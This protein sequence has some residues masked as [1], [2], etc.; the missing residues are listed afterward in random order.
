MPP[1]LEEHAEDIFLEGNKVMSLESNLVFRI[2]LII[3]FFKKKVNKEIKKT[4]EAS[5]IN[6]ESLLNA[7]TTNSGVHI[8]TNG[9]HSN[10]N[11]S[12]RIP[13]LEEVFQQFPTTPVNL[14]IKFNSDDLIKKVYDLILIINWVRLTEI[15]KYII[16]NKNKVHE[17][18][19]KYNR[20]KITIWGSFRENT[21]KKCYKLNSKV[22]LYFSLMGVVKLLLLSISGLL[23]FVPLKETHL[24]IIMPNNLLK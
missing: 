3:S 18:I 23:P 9:E 19:V 2:N 24:N 7:N 20:E 17:L 12:K 22:P 5:N 15:L 6:S 10:R 1:I 13:L 14:D 16:L 21:V 11:D 8:R 4:A